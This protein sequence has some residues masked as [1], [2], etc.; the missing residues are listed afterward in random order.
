MLTQVRSLFGAVPD[1]LERFVAASQAAQ[2]EAFR[3]FIE[4]FR[5]GMWRRTGIIWWNL[6]DGWPQFSDAVIDYYGVRKPAFEVIRRAQAPVSV[7][8]CPPVGGT[9]EVVVSNLR[10][11]PVDVVVEVADLD[12]GEVL[13]AATV[14]AAGDAATRVGQIA[15][16]P[17]RPRCLRLRWTADGRPGWSHHLVGPTPFELDRYLAWM[18]AL[19]GA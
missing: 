15:E 1:T 19:R 5:A 14:T 6:I 9:H 12:T 3:T 10:R 4:R 8:V 2:S 18:D 17:G 13:L 16:M 11:D 7:I